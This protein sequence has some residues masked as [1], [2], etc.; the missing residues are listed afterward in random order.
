MSSN[1][2]PERQTES[3]TNDESASGS[4]PPEPIT[5]KVKRLFWPLFWPVDRSD[6]SADRHAGF[7]AEELPPPVCDVCGFAIEEPGQDCPAVEQ[8]RCAA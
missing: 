5:I 1:T 6:R 3:T 8:G 7:D 4:N 2:H